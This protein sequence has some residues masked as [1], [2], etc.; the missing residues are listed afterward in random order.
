MRFS[1]FYL[2]ICH[3]IKRTLIFYIIP[4]SLDKVLAT[5]V[6]PLKAYPDKAITHGFLY[7]ITLLI[8]KSISLTK[9]L[10]CVISPSKFSILYYKLIKTTK[11]H[12]K[13]NINQKLLS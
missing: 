13:T 5:S 6:L 8:A 10:S 2:I 9:S 4:N 12:K 11:F 7:L 3:L 1:L